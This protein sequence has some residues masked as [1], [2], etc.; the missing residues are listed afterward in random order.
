MQ[1]IYLRILGWLAIGPFRMQMAEGNK[2]SM[3]IGFL[4]TGICNKL[5]DTKSEEGHHSE[6]S[7]EIISLNTFVIR[8]RKGYS[9]INMTLHI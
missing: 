3:K 6:V 9:D 1:N 7:E 4:W 2:Q 8:S 5:K